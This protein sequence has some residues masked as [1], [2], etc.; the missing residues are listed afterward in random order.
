M[1]R[2]LRIVIFNV[3][4]ILAIIT[5]FFTEH[6]VERAYAGRISTTELVDR[7]YN[8]CEVYSGRVMYKYQAKQAAL[9]TYGS[10]S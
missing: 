2:I 8:F 9:P 6:Y 1:Y 3:R 5:D 7:I 4:L 10:T